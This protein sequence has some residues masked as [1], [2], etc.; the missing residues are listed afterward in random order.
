MASVVDAFNEALSEDLS[1]VKIAVYSIPVYFCAKLF[2]VGKMS[3]FYFYGIITAILFLGLLT[4]G[5]NNV[6]LNKKE[7]LTFNPINLLKAIVSTTVALVPQLIVAWLIGDFIIKNIQIPID[8]PHVST[9]F[10]VIV[11]SLL[12]SIILTSYLSFAKYLRI[13][14]AFNYK[15]ILE[16]CVDVLVGFIFFIP[17]L[18]LANVVLVGPVAYLFYFFHLPFTHW[19]FVAYCSLAFVVNI[20]IL[21]N[22]LAQSSYEN[23]KGNNEEY[24][25]HSQ[26]D[27]IEEITERMG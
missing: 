16:S 9:I 12:F 17:Q 23:I 7:I 27:V 25:D 11:W 14:Q 5:F 4:F 24:N 15:V 2:L 3:E 21:A 18:A 10:A 26:T 1:L 13:L 22:Y 19:G 20:S 6:R 8:L